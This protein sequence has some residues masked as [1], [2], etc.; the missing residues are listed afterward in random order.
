MSS[1]RPSSFSLN[2]LQLRRGNPEVVCGRNTRHRSVRSARG[3]RPGGGAQP[4]SGRGAWVVQPL[5]I[6]RSVIPRSSLLMNSLGHVVLHHLLAGS[7]PRCRRLAPG[8]SPSPNDRPFVALEFISYLASTPVSPG[9]RIS[10]SLLLQNSRSTSP[11]S[12]HEL[13]SRGCR[14]HQPMFLV[15]IRSLPS[16]SSA[17]VAVT[18]RAAPRSTPNKRR[19]LYYVRRR[20]SPTNAHVE[21]ESRPDRSQGKESMVR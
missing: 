11:R 4:R 9:C 18:D 19:P 1:Y 7:F 6:W 20:R 5:L 16:R 2:P 3:V 13:R 8:E 21:V 17:L 14:P 15:D 12:L 10:P